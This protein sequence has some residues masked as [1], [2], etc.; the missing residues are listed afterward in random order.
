[1]RGTDFRSPGIGIAL[2]NAKRFQSKV[3]LQQGLGRVGRYND[4]CKRFAVG[5][6]ESD[7]VDASAVQSLH[8]SMYKLISQLI[9]L[10]KN[11]EAVKNQE[12][13]V[14]KKEQKENQFNSKIKN[15]FLK[16]NSQTEIKQALVKI[17]PKQQ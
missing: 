14:A 1:M 6:D 2:I 4:P 15:Q 3:D 16:E 12:K 13:N 7:L 5:K 17:Q 10:K 8:N 11:N 9:P